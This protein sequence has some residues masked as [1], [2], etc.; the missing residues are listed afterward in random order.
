MSKPKGFDALFCES[1][2]VSELTTHIQDQTITLAK[3]MV[4]HEQ[5]QNVATQ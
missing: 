5:R 1:A 4:G 2:Y 3:A